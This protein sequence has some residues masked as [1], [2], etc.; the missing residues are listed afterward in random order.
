MKTLFDPVDEN[1]IMQLEKQLISL[2]L[3]S[4]EIME[5][6]LAHVKEFQFKL[7]KF[8]KNYQKKDGQ[9]IELVLMNSRTPFDVFVSTFHTN[10]K[11]R[12]EDGNDY[13]FEYFYGILIIDHHRLFG[14]GNLGGK[15][16]DH[17]L[18]GK[19]KMDP[20]DRAWLD[21][22]TQQHA[23]HDHKP[24]RQEYAP[25]QSQKKKTCQYCGKVVHVKKL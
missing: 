13:T 8:G 24:Q 5:D 7:G 10:W 21:E 9:L 3:D 19:D 23:Y 18:K 14:E 11:E 17:L 22:Y 12:K 15:H 4:F 2:Y 20:K 1:H 25:Q 16:Q 6:Y